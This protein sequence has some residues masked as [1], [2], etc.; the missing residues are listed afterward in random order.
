VIRHRAALAAWAALA[1]RATWP[2]LAI[3]AVDTRCAGKSY[4][5]CT[6]VSTALPLLADRPLLTALAPC[7][8]F[9]ARA[10]ETVLATFA[11]FALLAPL[12]GSAWLAVDAIAAVPAITSS[13]HGYELMMM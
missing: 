3:L 10:W 12:T 9:T 7:S 11:A 1:L 5:P 13:T 2:T 6:P 4:G 8:G